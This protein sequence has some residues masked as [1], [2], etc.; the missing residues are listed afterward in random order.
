MNGTLL[1]KLDGKGKKLWPLKIVGSG[2]TSGSQRVANISYI[3]LENFPSIPNA[4]FIA[5]PLSGPAPLEVQFTDQ[6]TGTAPFTY[7]WDFENDGVIDSTLQN[8]KFTYTTQGTYAVNLTVTNGVGSD[9]ELRT[10]DITVNAPLIPPTAAFISDIQSGTA[11]LTVRFTDQST[12]SAP[13]TYAWDFDNDGITENTTQ[14]PSY[15]YTTAGTYTVNLTVT[16]GAGSDS[17]V[18]TG[19]ITV[20]EDTDNDSILDTEEQGPGGTDP[21]Y[22]GNGDGTPDSQQ[23]NVA[24]F[25]TTTD[26]YVT[27]VSLGGMYLTDVQAVD[28]PSPADIPEYLEMPFGFIDFAITGITPGGVVTVQLY[29][30]DRNDG[31]YLL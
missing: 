12:G 23:G 24:S 25:H 26:D 22:D 21:D 5:D 7:A 28:N 14:G 13:L 20:Q 15:T 11:P 10:G 1:P 8:P 29:L 30:P 9:S 27:L 16:N 19:Y 2:T 17:E 31:R 4:S 6:S 18:K 3:T